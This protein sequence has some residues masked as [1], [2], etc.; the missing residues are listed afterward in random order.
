MNKYTL[1]KFVALC[2]AS[3]YQI[4]DESRD[5]AYYLGK[6]FE[7]LSN[8]YKNN[9]DIEKVIVYKE[10]NREFFKCL[11]ARK[12]AQGDLITDKYIFMQD[13]NII[14][15]IN[16]FEPYE[17]GIF[18]QK[19]HLLISLLALLDTAN[20]DVNYKLP[21]TFSVKGKIN[22]IEVDKEKNIFRIKW[23]KN[24]KSY[25][26]PYYSKFMKQ[27]IFRTTDNETSKS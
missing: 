2:N 8:A 20:F 26:T 13:K 14:A 17:D 16:G 18:S 27:W 4:D 12:D 3:A 19:W 6:D 22:N 5:E 25:N 11:L 1:Q 15:E 10:N 21:N 7:K 23:I 9:E 24:E